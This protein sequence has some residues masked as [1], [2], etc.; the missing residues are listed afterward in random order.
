MK[1]KGRIAKKVR[2][3]VEQP[4]LTVYRSLHHVYAQVVDDTA[5]STLVAS[6]SLSPDL[7]AELKGVKGMKEVAKRVGMS[8]ARKA[9]DKKIT[10]VVFDRNG[11]RFHGIVK[12]MADGAREAGLKF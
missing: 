12:A 6:S 1:V 4:R 3:T 11:Y 7:R 8:V 2:G 5:A 9:I 10:R